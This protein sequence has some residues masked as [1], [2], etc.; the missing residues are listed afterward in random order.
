[1]SGELI[2]LLNVPGNISVRSLGS[3]RLRGKEQ[4]VELFTAN[5]AAVAG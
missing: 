3:E 4:P 5:R 2:D 1:L